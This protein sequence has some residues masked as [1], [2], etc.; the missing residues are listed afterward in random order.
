M[1]LTFHRLS[2]AQS[3]LVEASRRRMGVIG[4]KVYAAGA[5]LS[6]GDAPIHARRGHGLRAEPSWGLNR[7]H[8]LLQSEPRWTKMRRSPERFNLSMPWR[9]VS[10]KG[11]PVPTLH[12][13]LRTKDRLTSC[14]IS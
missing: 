12:I 4:M 2:F 11:V 1:W 8:R 9:C 5:L 13:T 7:R 14:C 10:L 6:G 3:V